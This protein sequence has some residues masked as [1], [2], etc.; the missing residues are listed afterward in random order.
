MADLEYDFGSGW[1]G[2]KLVS[3][4]KQG[5]VA[6]DEEVTEGYTLLGFSAGYR[7]STPWRHVIIFRID[8]LLDQS[9]RDHLSRVTDRNFPMPGRNFTLAYRLFF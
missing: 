7:L 4:A 1:I 2:G 5:R 8:N 6:P 3:A 9:Y